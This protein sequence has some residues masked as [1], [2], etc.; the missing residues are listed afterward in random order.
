MR[1]KT[2]KIMECRTL[3]GTIEIELPYGTDQNDLDN[4]L[5]H[6]ILSCIDDAMHEVVCEFGINICV[7]L[8]KQIG[9]E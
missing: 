1:I 8:D 6:R 3:E 2:T 4:G 9:D 5:R 7:I